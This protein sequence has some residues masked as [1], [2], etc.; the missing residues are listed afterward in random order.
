MKDTETLIYST[1]TGDTGTGS[2]VDL[3]GAATNI[4]FAFQSGQ[5][6]V[7]Q[8]T[9]FLFT[10]GPGNTLGDFARTWTEFYQFNIFSNVHTDILFRLKRL[11]DGRCFTVSPSLTQ[12]GSVQSVWDW[13]GPDGWD[14]SL[15]VMTKAVRF[16]FF[17][18]PKA[19]API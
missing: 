14:E 10:S 2:L 3:L 1:M 5:P 18:V 13:E 16:R 12:A 4:K 8:L 9:Y 7:P 19:Q 11:F 15:E 6:V 17:V